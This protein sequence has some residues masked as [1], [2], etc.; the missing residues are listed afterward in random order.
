MDKSKPNKEG[1]SIKTFALIYCSPTYHLLKISI[2]NIEWV[3]SIS[4]SR[5]ERLNDTRLIIFT[6]K[7]H[8][9]T[10][11][12][13]NKM[14]TISIHSNAYKMPLQFRVKT[15]GERVG[16]KSHFTFV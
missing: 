1:F 14:N 7:P 3:T 11:Q 8:Y 4:W 13:F 6:E 5:D 2:L 12:I 16:H 9:K 10:K 15:G